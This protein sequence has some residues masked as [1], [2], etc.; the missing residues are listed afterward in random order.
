MAKKAVIT[1]GGGFVGSNLAQLLIS[2]GYDTHLVDLDFTFRDAMLPKAAIRHTL[3]I[4]HTDELAQVFEGADMV[5]HTA[6]VPRV[7][8]SIEHPVETTDQNITVPFLY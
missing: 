1:G 7:P 8:Y 5:F 4:R 3:D 6:A 2:E